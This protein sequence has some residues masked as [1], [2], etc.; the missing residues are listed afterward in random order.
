[1][2]SLNVA[3]VGSCRGWVGVVPGPHVDTFT[4]GHATARPARPRTSLTSH[5]L[6]GALWKYPH[7]ITVTDGGRRQL[8]VPS[9]TLQIGREME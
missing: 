3:A 4:T 5:H 1:M 8:R 7:Y 2:I 9:G 6:A